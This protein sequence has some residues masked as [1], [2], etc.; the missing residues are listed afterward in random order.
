MSV[1]G[2]F[3][4]HT[5]FVLVTRSLPGSHC[6]QHGHSSYLLLAHHART[7]SNTFSPRSRYGKENRTALTVFSL[8]PYN[9]MLRVKLEK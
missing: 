9:T 6:V 5:T 1:A 2:T 4:F 8:R 7:K 3:H